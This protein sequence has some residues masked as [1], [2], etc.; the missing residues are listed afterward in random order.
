MALW[1]INRELE[2]AFME[3]IDPETGEII[4]DTSRLDELLLARDEKIENIALFIKNLDAE[5][6]A[7][8]AEK[9]NLAKRQKSIENRAEWLKKYLADNLQGESFKTAK[10]VISWRK[11]EVIEIRSMDDVP[12]DYLKF[13]EPEA[14]KVA[15]KKAIKAGQV[16]DGIALVEKNNIQIK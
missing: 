4:D 3:C 2:A 14:D 13:K 8:K 16:F 5:A 9:D 12:E 6:K 10:T 7:V 15:L 1:D 11:S